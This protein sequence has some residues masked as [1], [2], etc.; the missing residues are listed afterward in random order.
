MAGFFGK[1]FIFRAAINAEMYTLAVIGVL[2]S[3][4]A[5]FYY[6]RIV[7]IM[8]FDEPAERFDRPI[9]REISLILVGT[10]LFI[11]FFFPFVSPLLSGAGAAARSLFVG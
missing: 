4:V 10:G 6:L 3:V 1:F 8:Y 9:G 2:S 7:K 11:V 5:A